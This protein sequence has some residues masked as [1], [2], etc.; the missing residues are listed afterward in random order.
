MQRPLWLAGAGLVAGA[1]VVEWLHPVSFSWSETAL[2]GA[3]ALGAGSW[4]LRKRRS[5][6]PLDLK[7]TV[8]DRSAVERSLQHLD[9]LLT[10]LRTELPASAEARVAALQ[11][12]RADLQT[13]LDRQTLRVAVMGGK[14][15]GKTTLLTGLQATGSNLPGERLVLQDGTETAIAAADVVLFVTAGDLT[16][17]ELQQIQFYT[18]QQQR[19]LLAFNKQDQYLPPDRPLLL[20][21]LRER[22]C[23][24]VPLQDVVAIAAAPAPYKVRQHQPDGS[25]QERLQQPV[26][27]LAP[28]T[29]RLADLLTQTPQWVLNTVYRQSE[30]L[31]V[32]T[33]AALNQVRRDRALP[34]IEQS[35]WMTAAAAFATPLPSLD[36][37]ATAA[38]NAQLVKDLGAIYQQKFSLER[39]QTI[40]G[41]LGELMVKLGLVELSSQAIAPLLKSHALTF[42]AGGLLQGISAAY[43]TRIAGLTLVEY[44]EEQSAQPDTTADSPLNLERLTQKL[45]AVFQDNQRTAFLQT[46]VQQG[47]SRLSAP[48]ARQAGP[49]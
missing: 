7:P 5:P 43:L 46:L 12:R 4:F 20:Q 27:D 36:L 22:V 28:L 21:Q 19:V 31:R 47:I 39:E 16:D 40:A 8:I 11:T 29:E 48:V 42:V 34:L 45:K 2:W 37:L 9:T 6:L 15:V 38:I 30:A 1:W 26:A 35:Q 24:L 32:E 25:V 23:Q 13:E 17:S 41:T 10:R 18:E 33:Q 49:A 14:S 44:F 3:I